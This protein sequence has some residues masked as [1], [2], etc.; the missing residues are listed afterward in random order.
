MAFIQ[1]G[2]RRSRFEQPNHESNIAGQS[3]DQRPGR[4]AN[5]VVANTSTASTASASSR[6]SDEG[7]DWSLVFPGRVRSDEAA[8]R[9]LRHS[10]SSTTLAPLHDGTGQFASS[11]QNYTSGEGFSI[12]F[13]DDEEEAGDFSTGPSPDDGESTTSS[14]G[15]PPSLLLSTGDSAST[16]SSRVV[17]RTAA[18]T[19]RS[20][21][22]TGSTASTTSSGSVYSHHTA[23]SL[24]ISFGNSPQWSWDQADHRRVLSATTPRA[25]TP[26]HVQTAVDTDNDSDSEVEDSRQSLVDDRFE[27]ALESNPS[28]LSAGLLPRPRSRRYER[29]RLA[30]VAE[31]SSVLSSGVKRRHRRQAG[32]VRS[33]KSLKSESVHSAVQRSR[34]HQK[35]GKE[36][37][38]TPAP[39]SKTQRVARLLG[40]I[41]D[42]DN[43]ALDA[44]VYE[45]GPL[46]LSG[47]G[48]DD[49]HSPLSF[50]FSHE[51]LE[52]GETPPYAAATVRKGWRELIDGRIVEDDQDDDEEREGDETADRAECDEVEQSLRSSL[53]GDVSPAQEDDGPSPKLSFQEAVT[54]ALS[55]WASSTHHSTATTSTA[56]AAEA[57]KGVLPF[58][59]PFSWRLLVRLVKEWNDRNQLQEDKQQQPQ[60]E[61]PAVEERVDLAT[62]RGRSRE[63]KAL[64]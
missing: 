52:I 22:N 51:Q 7:D 44:V 63:R 12:F 16:S 55:Q 43:D 57:L 33:S 21:S 50:G 36:S 53:G 18:R 5:N 34:R 24:S 58:F 59:V 29:A 61:M 60:R 38:A 39:D 35:N 25:G 11:D 37:S 15:S 48:N 41:F 8:T 4:A 46:A 62:T 47:D 26:T 14:S 17:L 27:D 1:Q 3:Q 64:Q 6:P 42:V 13:D 56:A 20:F 30:D 28:A 49:T 31:S 40:R 19:Q 54:T 45:R 2:P 32:S 9:A 10:A 23:E